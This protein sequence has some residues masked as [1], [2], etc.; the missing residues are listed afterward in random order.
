MHA[1]CIC[2]KLCTLKQKHL[3]IFSAA[4]ASEL[5]ALR[6][7]PNLETSRRKRC[8]SGKMPWP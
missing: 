2:M 4:V 1:A 6:P 7:V 3:A 8:E 5:V